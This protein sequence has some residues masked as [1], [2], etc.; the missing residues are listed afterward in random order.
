[1][2]K[3]HDKKLGATVIVFRPKTRAAVANGKTNGALHS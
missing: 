1:V 3:M 2:E